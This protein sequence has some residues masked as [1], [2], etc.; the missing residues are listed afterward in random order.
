MSTA[1]RLRNE[2]RA[3]ERADNVL[4]ILELRFGLLPASAKAR[5]AGADM[6]TLGRWLTRLL[7]ADSLDAALE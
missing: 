7:S 4:R 2:G 6:D 3:A 5:V 1:E